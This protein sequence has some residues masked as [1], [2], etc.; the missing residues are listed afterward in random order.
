MSWPAGT[1]A[2]RTSGFILDDHEGI[3]GPRSIDGLEKFATYLRELN[4]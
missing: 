2:S 4:R 1:P 3:S